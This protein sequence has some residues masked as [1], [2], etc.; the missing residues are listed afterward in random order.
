VKAGGLPPGGS[1]PFFIRPVG[2]QGGISSFFPK[3]NLRKKQ[4]DTKYINE[5]KYEFNP[6]VSHVWVE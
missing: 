5:N 6:G 2:R 3:K 1:P 4:I